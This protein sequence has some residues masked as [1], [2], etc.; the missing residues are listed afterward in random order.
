MFLLALVRYIYILSFVLCFIDRSRDAIAMCCAPGRSPSPMKSMR[1]TAN[2]LDWDHSVDTQFPKGEVFNVT[3]NIY[4][5]L[6]RKKCLSGNISEI[7][8]TFHSD[9]I[10]LHRPPTSSPGFVLSRVEEKE[11]WARGLP[12]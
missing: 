10:A 12:S 8:H 4:I 11:A 2:S 9:D 7:L 1:E 5:F 6:P 3:L